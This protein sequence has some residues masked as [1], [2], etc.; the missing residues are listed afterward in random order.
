MD[1]KLQDG[2]TKSVTGLG[3]GGTALGLGIAGTAL[4]LMNGGSG[5]LGGL[6][7]GNNRTNIIST[8]GASENDPVTR[9]EANMML[10]LQAKDC[11]IANLKADQYTDKK[12]VEVF[13]ALNDKANNLTDRFNAKFESLTERIHQEH[14][15]QAAINMQ[16]AVYNGT[17]TATI[18]NLQGQITQLQSLSQMVI[19]QRNVCNT[20]CGCP[21]AQ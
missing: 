20:C 7:G 5:L 17:N 16:Q 21:C 9:Y 2:T 4:G 14:E 15:Q 18:A 19:P 11:E 6:F 10:A 3:V 1:I 13:N 12:L 8:S